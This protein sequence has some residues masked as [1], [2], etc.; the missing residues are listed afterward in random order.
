MTTRHVA[1]GTPIDILL[2][3]Y[4]S[5][6]SANCTRRVDCLWNTVKQSGHDE[7]NNIQGAVCSVVP[8]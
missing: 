3:Y 5:F 2:L 6:N 1:E 4:A 7:P 8:V